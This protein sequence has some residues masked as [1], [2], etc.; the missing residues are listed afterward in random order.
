MSRGYEYIRT[1]SLEGLS[2]LYPRNL[3][4]CS[5][6]YAVLVQIALLDLNYMSKTIKFCILEEMLFP[7]TDFDRSLVLLYRLIKRS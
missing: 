4:H 1:L 5:V 6:R 3:R 2:L 7:N